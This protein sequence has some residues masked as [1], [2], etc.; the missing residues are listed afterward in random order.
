MRRAYHRGHQR[1]DQPGRGKGFPRVAGRG[2]PRRDRHPH[3][4]RG[5]RRRPCHR[6]DPFRRRCAIAACPRRRRGPRNPRARRAGLSRYRGRDIGRQGDRMRRRASGLWFPQRERHARPA[7]H[8]GKHRLCRAVAGGA[9]PVRRQGAGQG[10]GKTM[11][12]AH[13]RGH[14]RADQPGR[15]KG[16]PGI[17]GRRRRHHDQGDRRRRRPRHAHRRR[18]QQ[19]W[20]RPM[21]AASPRRWP[22]SAAT[23][24]MSS[25]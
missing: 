2:Q 15:G 4:P 8:R 9:R 18:R 20:R 16:L 13:H 1:A 21:R 25:A 11:R 14:Q 17:P 24:S 3:C 19:S 10:A 22:P 5:G 12:R 23:A 6:R 7:L